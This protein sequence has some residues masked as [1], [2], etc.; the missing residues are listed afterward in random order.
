MLRARTVQGGEKW[1]IA[2]LEKECSDVGLSSLATRGPR[3]SCMLDK[4]CPTEA[5]CVTVF[6]HTQ[7]NHLASNMVRTERLLSVS[8][9]PS[10][11]SLSQLCRDVVMRHRKPVTV[12]RR[13][14]WRNGG[15]GRDQSR[16]P[17]PPSPDVDKG[18][19][20]LL[21]ILG[22]APQYRGQPSPWGASPPS[23]SPNSQ[24]PDQESWK[25]SALPSQGAC[26]LFLRWAQPGEFRIWGTGRGWKEGLF[27]ASSTRCTCRN[28]G[29]S[30]V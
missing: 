5:H 2:F 9:S 1:F 28:T 13:R 10:L 29:A 19:Q 23:C 30:T 16:Q 15:Q 7:E 21:M 22:P 24:E 6:S 26:Q 4:H 27:N 20:A 11:S 3:A 14:A 17:G 18:Q 25:Q 12:P 8:A